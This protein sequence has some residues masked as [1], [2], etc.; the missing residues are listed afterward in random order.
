MIVIRQVLPG[1]GIQLAAT[2]RQSDRDEILA[3]HGFDPEGGVKRS[4]ALSTDVWT[5]ARG[6][7]V[8]AVFGVAVL[9]A[10]SGHGTVWALTSTVVDRYPVE[11]YRASRKVVTELR[12]R[13]SLLTNAISCENKRALRW[14]RRIGFTIGDP[15]PIGLAGQLFR[16][17]YLRS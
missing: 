3:S 6:E 17:I 8:L 12:A 4:I 9:N 2:M 16:R 1:D 5:G 13:Y 15:V 10:L 7:E 11:F 14:A